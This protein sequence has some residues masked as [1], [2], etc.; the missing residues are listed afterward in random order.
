MQI[1][2]CPRSNHCQNSLQ[3]SLF[4]I[5]PTKPKRA[6]NETSIFPQMKTYILTTLIVLNALT[7]NATIKPIQ[8]C[9]GFTGFAAETQSNATSGIS[10]ETFNEVIDKLHRLYDNDFK[11]RGARLVIDRWWK[12]PMVNA[13][14]TKWG[15][16][17]H[18]SM[19][20]ALARRPNM[21]RDAFALVA[22]HEIGHHLGGPPFFKG[23]TADEGEADYFGTLKC[24]RRF[25]N[26]EDND[27]AIA[28]LPKDIF[29]ESECR[30]EFSNQHDAQI[31][32]RSA[33]A[34]STLANVMRVLMNKPAISFQTPD[35]TIVTTINHQHPDPQCRLDT[36]LNGSRCP[37]PEKEPLSLDSYFP[38]TCDRAGEGPNTG[39]RPRCWFHPDALQNGWILKQ[40]NG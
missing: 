13:M 28:K 16:S 21:T 6:A 14:A 7:A 19:F 31:C 29:L 8:L 38:G 2:W 34:G 32:I 37:V 1:F 11:E 4:F 23:T 33:Q 35:K 22:C 30:A 25:F 12:F 39:S 26:D 17:W 18:V 5:P 3:L 10:K 27:A 15:K 9:E 40:A 24:L 36:Y 20:G